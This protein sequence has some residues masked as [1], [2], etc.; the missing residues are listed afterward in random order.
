MENANILYKG[1]GLCYESAI[2]IDINDMTVRIGS[3]VLLEHASAHVSDGQ[4]VGLVGANGC[5]KSTLFRILKGELETETGTVFFPGGYRVVFVEQEIR[6]IDVSVLDFLLASDTER[7][8]LMARL[9][10][11]EGEELAEI[12]ERL[13]MIEASSAPARAAEILHGLGFENE[14]FSRPVREFSGGWRMRL[15][16]AA[17]LFQP[18]EVLLLDEPTNH[19]DLEASLWLEDYL[20]K[21]RGTLI[22]ISHDRSILNTLCDYI[23]HFDNKKLVSYGGNY[24][25]FRK[26]RAARQETLL[27]QAA[28]QEQQRRHLQSFID[29]FR[30]KASKAKQAQSRIKMLEKLESVPLLEDEAS[31]RFEFPEAEELPPPLITIENGVAGY[32][33]RPVLKKLNLQI[34]DNDRVA[35]LGANG[36]GKSTLARVLS[37]RLPLM[38]GRMLR[39]KKLK[40]GYFAQHQAEE[41]P[42]D[43]T[44]VKFMATLMPG[45]PEPKLRAHIARFGLGQEKAVTRIGDLSGGEKARLLFAAMTCNAPEILI[46][47]EPTNHLDIDGREALIRA[48]NEYQGSVILITHDLHLIELIADN[49]WLV[50]D[51]TCRPYDGDLEDYRRLLLEKPEQPKEQKIKA[52][53]EEVKINIRE[54]KKNINARLRRIEREME[55]LNTDRSAVEASFQN[56]TDGMEIVKKQKELA[57]ISAALGEYEDEWLDLSEKLERLG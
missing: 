31:T 16:L 34:V 52:K 1:A 39:S 7:S 9:D 42:L 8:A 27:R 20:R 48:L 14:D 23:I 3:K 57:W 5:G 6:D 12:H 40:V 44:P 29:R 37:E 53:T 50:R 24:D 25:T 43:L 56:L 51:G 33:G 49:L 47:D 10:G 15:S 35:L 32:D 45:V 54:E 28:R 19:L 21:Y 38:E 4:K 46:L 36:N 17:A 2:M 22:V 41:L 11:A 18:S 26:T 30:Y 55:K 13:N